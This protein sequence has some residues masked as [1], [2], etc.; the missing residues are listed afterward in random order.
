MVATVATGS[1]PVES[2]EEVSCELDAKSPNCCTPCASA[3]RRASSGGRT[4]VPYP[5]VYIWSQCQ[6]DTL[7]SRGHRS[8]DPPQGQAHSVTGVK[9]AA[10][11]APA[12][13]DC[14]TDGG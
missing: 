12:G 13:P 10:A 5:S 3:E 1:A 11:L 2:I 8:S 7:S 9:C 14:R 4:V 6:S